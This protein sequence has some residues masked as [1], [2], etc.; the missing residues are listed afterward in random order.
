M[1]GEIYEKRIR[2]FGTELNIL[3][4]GDC[5]EAATANGRNMI[6]LI[7]ETGINI[8]GELEA[9]LSK[10]KFK[11]DELTED[12]PKKRGRYRTGEPPSN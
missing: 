5:F 4:P 7:P 12:G 11:E 2:L 9:P 3:T 1:G 10:L 8:N 6:L